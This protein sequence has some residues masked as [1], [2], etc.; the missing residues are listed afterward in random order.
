MSRPGP[1]RQS[2]YQEIILKPLA[3]EIRLPLYRGGSATRRQKDVVI[4]GAYTSG[5]SVP[6]K[7]VA[8]RWSTLDMGA[9]WTSRPGA[10][11]Q[12]VEWPGYADGRNICTRFGSIMPAGAHTD[13]APSAAWGQ[14]TQIITFNGDVFIVFQNRVAYVPDGTGILTELTATNISGDSFT[15]A[16]VYNGSLR[17]ANVCTH[18]GSGAGTLHGIVT[19]T[20]SGSSYNVT[21]EDET[22]APGNPPQ[23]RWLS[24]V[25]WEHKGV[26]AYRLWGQS[27]DYQIQYMTDPEGDVNDPADWSD[28][29]NVGETTYEIRQM[30]ASHDTAW[31]GKQDGLYAI[32]DATAATGGINLTPYWRDQLDPDAAVVLYYWQGYVVAAHGLGIDLVDVNSWQTQDAP[33]AIHIS[34]GRPN[35]GRLNGRYTAFCSDGPWLVASLLNAAGDAHTLYGTPRTREGVAGNTLMDWFGPEVSLDDVEITAMAVDTPE[36]TLQPRLW[37][38]ARTQAGVPSLRWV[39]LFRGSTPLA[40]LDMGGGHRFNTSSEITL[41]D[42][43]FG[44]SAATKGALRGTILVEGT[45]DGRKVDLYAAVG[46]GTAFS[47]TPSV[48]V[49]AGT[50]SETFNLTTT[51]GKVIR[52][53]LVLTGTTTRPVVVHELELKANLG[54]KLRDS[55]TYTVEISDATAGDLPAFE[56]E[57]EVLAELVALAESVEAFSMEDDAGETCTAVL[58]NV[59]T[60]KREERDDSEGKVRVATIGVQ[61]VS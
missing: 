29:I 50:E 1:G 39:S 15:N 44:A 35:R 59:V 48:T 31:I 11:Q 45:G 14:P 10:M 56:D 37:V 40:D 23:L 54:F 58:D 21:Q 32:T 17:V 20:P 41:T 7:D 28:V 26:A 55:R 3:G 33:K 4:G 24:V 51:R 5:E 30:V 47:G 19:I 25:F 49:D 18:T 38:G 42:E 36:A 34:N 13:L 8:R 22:Y 46:P 60:W 61:V 2:S 52:T 9:G 6:T 27:S 57:S 16:V 53:K 12:G 43:V